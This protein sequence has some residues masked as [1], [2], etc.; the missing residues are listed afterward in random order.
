MYL[1][2]I[3][4][5]DGVLT[6]TSSTTIWFQIAEA[7]PVRMV[8]LWICGRALAPVSKTTIPRTYVKVCIK[9]LDNQY[10]NK[11]P[12]LLIFKFSLICSELHCCSGRTFLWQTDAALLLHTVCEYTVRVSE[13][14]PGLPM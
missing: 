10:H 13:Y 5:D 3:I 14:V 1:S 8:V 9:S 4:C 6:L 11:N 2:Y 7:R 12:E